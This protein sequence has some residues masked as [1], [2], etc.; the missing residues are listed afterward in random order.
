VL[1]F[2]FDKLYL[3][4]VKEILFVNTNRSLIENYNVDRNNL[5]LLNVSHYHD[6]N[7]DMNEISVDVVEY[8]SMMINEKELFVKINEM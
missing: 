2:V 6:N 1:D 5:F 3:K 7:K 4:D 8:Y